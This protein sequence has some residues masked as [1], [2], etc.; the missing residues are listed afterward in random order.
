MKVVKSITG[1]YLL[2][3]EAPTHEGYS[4]T[5]TTREI[6]AGEVT[7]S[8]LTDIANQCEGAKGQQPDPTRL[9]TLDGRTGQ[10]VDV[11]SFGTPDGVVVA[12]GGAPP[13]KIERNT[14][15]PVAGAPPQPSQL[16]QPALAES[17]AEARRLEQTQA[18]R[19]NALQGDDILQ[20]ESS[21]PAA[22]PLGPTIEEYV[23]AG[24]KAETY[25]PAGFQA[26]DTV[27][28]QAEQERRKGSGQGQAVAPG[29]P[30][31]VTQPAESTSSEIP[32]GA[33]TPT[34]PPAKQPVAAEGASAQT[35]APTPDQNMQPGAAAPGNETI[36]AP[37]TT[38][39]DAPKEK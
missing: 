36:G 31:Q 22:L 1:S 30:A 4:G 33:A 15:V 19:G 8:E 24:Y 26:V 5:P 3:R 9:G 20:P 23:R 16:V 37:P 28:W 29:S 25:P 39:P 17:L 14:D 21:A 27:G 6:V 38:A 34:E 35:G 10:P 32:Q 7:E 18:E 12:V 2:L 13:V 11:P